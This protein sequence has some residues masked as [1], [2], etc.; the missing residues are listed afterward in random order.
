MLCQAG[1]GYGY[2]PL[3]RKT[4]LIVKPE[5]EEIAGR[6]FHGSGVQITT[7]G[8]RHMG[9]AVGSENF[10]E[11]YVKK[12]VEKWVEDVEELA[13]IA[14]DEPQ[15]VY[16]S[17]TKAISHRWTYVQRTI[18][19]IDHLFT[20][21]E[22]A[23]RE[24]LI[25]A[26]IGRK[27][28]NIE[29]RIMALPVRLGG[30]GIRDPTKASEEFRAS[31][32]ITRNLTQVILNQ[33]RDF[34]NYDEERVKKSIAEVKAEKDRKLEQ[35]LAEIKESNQIDAGLIRI[36]DLLR[37]KGAGLWLTCLPIQTLGQAFNKEEFQAAVC[38]RYDKKVPGTPSHCQ[39][40]K[41]N[42]INHMLNCKLGGYVS[43]RH[44]RVRDLEAEL[45]RE[46]C[47]DVKIEPDLIPIESDATRTGNT[48]HKAR[49]DVS[50]VGVWGPYEKTFLDIR[51]MHPN[52]PSYMDKPI[53]QVFLTHENEK[54]NHYL[55]RVLQIE[56]GSFTPIV[57]S[58]YTVD[59]EKKLKDTTKGLRPSL[60]KKRTKSTRMS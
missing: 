17:F 56:K 10:K 28:S 33:E 55:E 51:V 45:M 13:R 54:K 50:G 34:S 5:H 39:C 29:R 58:T 41:K 30:L 38:V 23:I 43:M 46:V 15:V 31:S 40:G 18:P 21:L 32:K 9:A 57:L 59:V 53:E 6:I 25:P 4:V 44:N 52:S 16:S 42:D 22:E 48:A 47:H 19:D 11:M 36:L 2:F 37:S 7:E 3:P 26:I 14:R 8:E 12:K 20:P 60:L 35:E 27:I 49:L 1:P 24:I